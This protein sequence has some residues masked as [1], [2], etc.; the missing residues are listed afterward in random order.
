MRNSPLVNVLLVMTAIS[1]LLSVFLCWSYISNAR[2]LRTLQQ[3][4]GMANQNRQV[5][6]AL[7]MDALEYSKTN[8]AINPILEAVGAKP[9]TKTGTPAPKTNK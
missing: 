7:A 8:P 4:I 1:A 3:A 2:Q 9:S 5:M 6:N